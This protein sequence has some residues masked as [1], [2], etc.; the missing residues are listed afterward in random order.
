VVEFQ[1]LY[2]DGK[3]SASRPVRVRGWTGELEISG[4]GVRAR[5]PTAAV[6][7]EPPIG[8]TRR[9]LQLPEGAQLQTADEAAVEALFPEANALEGRIHRLERHWPYALA[10]VLVVGVV[11]WWT[12]VYG[13]PIAARIAAD[14]VPIDVEAALGERTLGTLDSM[15]CGPSKLAPKRMAELR[16]RFDALTRGLDDGF[17]YRLEL[18]ECRVIGANA[19]ALP[20]GTIV[21]TD[22]LV[23]LARNDDELVAVLA[24]EVGHVR[25]RHGLRLAFQ[26]L[27]V[28]ALIATLFG[29]AASLSTIIVAVPS[30]LVQTGYSRAFEEEADGYAFVRLKEI[31]IS[32]RHFADML[33]RLE[34]SR[35]GAARGER[36]L[37]YLSSHP[38]TEKRIER[39]LAQ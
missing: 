28:G 3:S 9:I 31:G 22:G 23:K 4:D 2:Y 20:A 6:K 5:V 36:A 26:S 15:G 16:G 1:A 11:A 13:V 21:M 18:R 24:H 38:A 19:F 33:R 10:A 29:D 7:V 37:D 30:V 25:Y 39:A 12:V 14:A 34:G 35:G 27:G 17:R 32:P 8:A